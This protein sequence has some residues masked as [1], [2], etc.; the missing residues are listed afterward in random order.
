MMLLFA[1][2][3]SLTAS[4]QKWLQNL[5]QDKSRSEYTLYDYRDAFNSYWDKYNVKGGYYFVDSV[6]HKA[7]GWKQFHRWYWD[8]ETKIDPATGKF[9]NT[10]A[11]EQFNKFYD[12]NPAPKSSSGSW[13]EM[14]PNSSYGGYAGVGRLN[15]VAFHPT[16]TNTYWVGAPAGGLWVTTN[17]G[18][19]WTCL[20]D[21][22]E[23]MGVSDIVI[24]SDYASSQTIYIA[25]GDRDAFDNRSHGVLKS[26]N[27]GST[28][29]TTGLTFEPEDLQV[30]NRLLADPGN[31][32]T[33]IAA[34]N[35]GV[36]KTVNG[37]T[38]WSLLYDLDFID[39]EY[40]PGVFSTLYGSTTYGTVYISTNGG[41]SWTQ[42]L[43]AFDGQRTEMAVSVNQPNW[44]Y[45]VV[46]DSEDGLLGIYKST[47]SG[48]SF[49]EVLP[50]YSL[51]LLCWDSYGGEVGGQG[52][53]DLAIAASPT[54]ANVLL[55]GGVNTWRSIDGG[56][57][58]EIVNHW[59]GDGVPAVHA[60]KHMLSFRGNGDLFECND[61]GIYLSENLGADWE[62]KTNGIVTSQM[63]KLSNS[64]TDED[65]FIAGLQDN[66]TKMYY[67]GDWWDVKGGDGMECLIDYSNS[68]IQYGTYVYG[69][70]DRTTDMWNDYDNIVDISPNGDPDGAWVTP[71]IIDPVNP[72]ILY[73]GYADVYKSTNRGDSW[74]MISN[75]N[76]FDKIQSIA[77][78]P[79][80]TQVLYIADYTHIWKTTNGGTSWTDITGTL[81][82][83]SAYIRYVTIKNDDPNTVWVCMSGY[84]NPGVYQTVNG[85]TSWTNISAGLPTFPVGSVVQNKLN[86]SS[87][88][89]YCGTDYGVYIKNGSSNWQLFNN[90]L[91]KV[92][93]GELEIWYG[94][95]ST[96]SKIR[97][98]TYGRGLWQSDLYSLSNPV[99]GTASAV[100][101]VCSGSTSTLSLAGST[102]NI[103]WQKSANGTS[104]WT[105]VSGGSG[106]NTATYTTGALSVST[107]FRA[108][109]S[110]SGYT[111]VYSNVVEV[112]INSL[113]AAAG[114]ISG[115][116]SVCQGQSGEIYTVN[117]IPN[118]NSYVWTLP[119]GATG[120]SAT[121]SLTVAYGSAA[122]S[123]NITVAGHN[124]CGNG[125]SSSL[126]ITVNP[127]TV[128]IV[129]DATQCDGTVTL[130][131]GSGFSSYVWDGITGDQY[132][133]VSST[134]TY[135]VIVTNS[136]GCT[137]T[138][139]ILVSISPLPTVSLGD[140]VVQCGGS[141]TLDAGAGFTS[142]LWNGAT[143]SRY[144]TAN[145]T[146]NYEVIVSNNI[147]C[148]ASDV[149]H[150]TINP[151]PDLSF[152]VVP[153]SYAGA[154]DASITMTIAGGTAPYTI[155][156]FNDTHGYFVQNL[157]AGYYAVE[158]VDYNGCSVSRTVNIT[159]ANGIIAN[160][161]IEIEIYPNP[162]HDI[163]RFDCVP[164]GSIVQIFDLKGSL[165]QTETITINNEINVSG[166]SAGTY[167]VI[168]TTNNQEAGAKKFV[169][170]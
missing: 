118:A 141:V 50:G 37:G 45:A 87:V 149:I 135:S 162:V 95:S 25:T 70:I 1:S 21:D 59:W 73:I 153:E 30:I 46:S 11:E 34:T 137:A 81:P 122:Q 151:V 158:V 27:G 120:T 28:W 138:D 7:G 139:E 142:Y 39:M 77:I 63:Y 109:L 35:D 128:N 99:A 123:G 79:S 71:Y 170:E 23:V 83:A 19:S 125:P 8:M 93:I 69:Q 86:T 103:Q 76:S 13:V 82:I 54:D 100:S 68:D 154:A 143:G 42:T 3:L 85:G 89:L 110:L 67:Y 24:N 33:L 74:T 144:R 146:G 20:T 157:S 145:T 104:G 161:N 150:V 164:L 136:I 29:N 60:D 43:E 66:G 75:I 116:A 163:L 17:N 92:K 26:I 52:W 130:D 14:G 156:W 115:S 51:N 129:E 49:V 84:T 165:L 56:N 106:A 133:T 132:N 78:A 96:T 22:N 97:A 18:S 111:T 5:P 48:A 32:N 6:K 108:S 126:S 62:D 101:P 40:K 168:I 64:A 119:I 131:A 114:A 16:N 55:V 121:S 10:T 15:C 38:S 140:D 94:S 117:T 127:I 80:N 4:A 2:L 134:G 167:I 98:A 90:G 9:P 47:N 112:V 72:Q 124:T 147:G 148:T 65:I 160:N 36:Y 152:V 53:Y 44:I 58:W 113:P 31:V 57:N 61:G 159:V 155:N 169:K 88:E 12:H 105:N 107:F 102:G 41:T 91:P 166:L